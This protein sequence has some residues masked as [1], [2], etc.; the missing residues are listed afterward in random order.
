MDQE[1][2]NA[3]IKKLVTARDRMIQDRRAH[4]EALA[5]EYKGEHTEKMRDGFIAAQ[6]AIEAI[7]RAIACESACNAREFTVKRTTRGLANRS[8]PFRTSRHES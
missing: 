3:H 4:A 2:E 1:K 5:S 6:K 7:D 8:E